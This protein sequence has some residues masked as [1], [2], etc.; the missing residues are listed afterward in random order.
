MPKTKNKFRVFLSAAEPSGD[1]HSAGLITALQSRSRDI[2]FVGV[3]GPKMA[4]AGCELLENTVDKAA[5]LYNAFTQ[6]ARFYKLVKRIR[7]YLASHE[8]DLV[9]VC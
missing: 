1:V 4:E 7:R 9:I 5:M 6:V 8:V 2:E 3:G